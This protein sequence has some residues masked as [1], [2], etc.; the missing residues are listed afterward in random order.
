MSIHSPPTLEELARQAL[1][2]N[3]ALA[4]SALETLP[5][6]LFP[7]LFVDA[8]NGKHTRIVKAMVAAWPLPYLPVGALM[9]TFNL[10]VLQDMLEGLDVLLTQNV[11]PR[12]CKLREIDFRSVNHHF[13]TVWAG[14]EEGD[15]SAE[16]VSE[17][18]EVKPPLRY[19]LTGPLKVITDLYFRFQLDEK[20]TNFLQWAQQRKD[21]LQLCC[22]NMKIE[23]LSL[24]NVRK[25]L[26]VF[27]P[28]HIQV[29]ELSI[30]W[31][32]CTLAQFSPYLAQ[33]RNLHTLSLVQIHKN[34][35]GLD[36]TYLEEKNLKTPLESFSVTHCL[37]FRSHLSH[38]SQCERLHQL[39]HLDM[40]GVLL[41][42]M[43]C[44][45]PLRVLL[46]KVASTL[47]TLGFQGC[48]I[49]DSQLS[50]LLPAL[51]QCSKLTKINFYFN[52]FSVNALSDLFLHTAN[53]T[54]MAVEQYP[55]PVECYDEFGYFSRERFVQL[56]PV[57]MDTLRPI[58]Q[59][60]DISFGVLLCG[61]C[62]KRYV[63]G[64][65]SR[66]CTCQR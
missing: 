38:L 16:T 40:C 43:L 14:T 48:G 28:E 33:M 29:L 61:S 41:S 6:T 7:P 17:E 55:A 46:E 15:C 49:T 11:H 21:S 60:K 36:I 50:V 1:L 34:R 63:Y 53:F 47:E 64:L 66:V 51:S 22:V 59:P 54:K 18:Q 24:D 37:V 57:L 42:Y 19:E 31:S 32:W 45:N 65:E 9:N 20:E 25:I 58:R 12:R 62:N 27:Q 56:C 4:I 23:S 8:F 13:W 39:K 10:E 30:D 44:M 3:E 35:F 26:T 52:D 5:W 2:R